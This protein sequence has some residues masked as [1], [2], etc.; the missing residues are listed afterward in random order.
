MN[1]ILTISLLKTIVG[2]QT[3]LPNEPNEVNESDNMGMGLEIVVK[4]DV[5]DEDNVGLEIVVKDDKKDEDHIDYTRLFTTDKV[6][7]YV[8]HN[9]L[10]VM[11]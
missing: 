6:C 3:M 9:M 7:T 2:T 11:L 10:Y 4:D 8:A 5:K 1:I